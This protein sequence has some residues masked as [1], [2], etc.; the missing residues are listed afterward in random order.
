MLRLLPLD[1]V[2]HAL[3]GMVAAEVL[4]Q[5]R[6]GRDR[7][8]HGWSVAAYLAS[9]AANNAPDLDLFYLGITEGKLGYLV[10]HRG[11]THTLVFALPL[12]LL[13]LLPVWLYARR[14]DDWKP[15]DLRAIFGLVSLGPVLHLAMDASNNY[16]VHPFWPFDNRWFYGDT[17]FIV[18]PL[19]WASVCPAL[20][21]AVRSK[22]AKGFFAF[23]VGGG[24]LL[25]AVSGRVPIPLVGALAVW[26]AA[27]SFIAARL[28]EARRGLAAIG[29]AAATYLLFG[30][31]SM[32]AKKTV[33]DAYQRLDPPETLR[34][35]V[36]T[37]APAN[38]FCWM[39]IGISDDGRDAVLR[40]GKVSV[41]GMSR[42]CASKSFFAKP[43][44]PLGPAT[45]G[46]AHFAVAGTF[47]APLPELRE[48]AEGC[49]AAA[50]MQWGRAPFWRRDD[51][52]T[53]IGDLRYDFDEGIGWAEVALPP[54]GTACPENL[55]HWT[56]PRADWLGR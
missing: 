40:R 27:V 33:R 47:R 48:L 41:L 56:P 39:V 32:Q 54:E 7:A 21:F 37:P 25:S 50:F 10:H 26:T 5:R 3:A 6:G 8:P 30:F 43:T 28:P 44:A 24:L 53:V 36:A 49:H 42:F 22:A 31:A 34:D 2:T 46:T 1:N 9:A 17:I 38:P 15:T 45:G 13:V 20:F 12:A 23:V 55:P 14:R 35:V 18:E 19:L 16:G 52:G 29:A 11:H 4:L 51:T